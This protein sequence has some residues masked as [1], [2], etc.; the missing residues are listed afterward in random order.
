MIQPKHFLIGCWYQAAFT[1]VGANKQNNFIKWK[2]RGCNTTIGL[3]SPSPDCTHQ[4][5]Y[6]WANQA[7]LAAITPPDPTSLTA[8]Q[9]V[10]QPGFGGWMQTDEPE[11]WNYY[12]HN[13]DGTWNT[14]TWIN[15]YLA[16]SASLKAASPSSPIFGNFTG[17]IIWATPT[18]VPTNIACY[19]QWMTGLDWVSIDCYP[20]NNGQ[21]A[22]TFPAQFGL[23]LNLLTQYSG[24]KPKMCFIECSHINANDGNPGPTPA[25]T[26]FEAWC[27]VVW[28]VKGICYFSHRLSGGDGFTDD[29]TTPQMQAAITLLN[30][31][32]NNLSPVLIQDATSVIQSG[33]IYT[34]QR[35]LGSDTYVFAVNMSATNTETYNG[36]SIAP[37]SASVIKNGQLYFTSTS[38]TPAVPIPSPAPPTKH[39]TS[40]V[41]TGASDTITVQTTQA[42]VTAQFSDGSSTKLY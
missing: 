12:I 8:S 26:V 10:L 15:Q 22:N 11:S 39:L 28:G 27:A 29:A 24:G 33:D 38:A 13:P 35:T 20:T 1:Y 17:S 37:L 3:P 19:T 32:L 7:G 23:G 18:S 4:A 34:S 5:Y 25:D 41:V 42:S 9:D 21:L 40:I 30:Q 16:L 31:S 2:N 14:Q 6:Q 36:V